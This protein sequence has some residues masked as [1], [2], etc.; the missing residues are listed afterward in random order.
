[1]SRSLAAQLLV[2]ASP[3]L[4]VELG[5]GT[6]ALLG[7]EACA[8]DW[9]A[10]AATFAALRVAPGSACLWAAAAGLLEDVPSGTPFGLGGARRALLVAL[11][12]GERHELEQASPVFRILACAGLAFAD[13]LLLGL[14]LAAREGGVPLG[15]VAAQA[16]L[17]ALATAVVAPVAWPALEL[18]GSE[19]KGER[20]AF[21]VRRASVATLTPLE[22]DA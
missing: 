21:R 9:V 12:H 8:P 2:L 22:S 7:L 1:M 11:L 10:I 14:E 18:L 17:I 13:K 20:P 19:A 4:L 16:G 5:R 6:P 15:A 3:W